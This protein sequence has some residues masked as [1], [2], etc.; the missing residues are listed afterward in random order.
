M[1]RASLAIV[2][3]VFATATASAQK[4]KYTRNTEVKVDVKLSDRSKPIQPKTVDPKTIAPTLSADDVM[5]IAVAE[6]ITSTPP[7]PPPPP[8]HGVEYWLFPEP[9]S[10]DSNRQDE[11]S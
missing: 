2:G 3:V 11:K 7:A 4:P 6:Y 5:S 10:F 9:P 1:K 8:A